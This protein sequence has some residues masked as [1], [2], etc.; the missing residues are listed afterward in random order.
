MLH[1]MGVYVGTAN[2]SSEYPPAFVKRCYSVLKQSVISY[3]KHAT[4]ELGFSIPFSISADKD[5][6]I[7]QGRSL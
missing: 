6:S 1:Q 7:D 5:T 2:H 3:M 4:T